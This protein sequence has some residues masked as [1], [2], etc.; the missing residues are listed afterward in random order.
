MSFYNVIGKVMVIVISIIVTLMFM[1][2]RM[3]KKDW[4]HGFCPK[5]NIRWRCFSFDSQGGRGY[6][7]PECNEHIWI[8][9]L[10]D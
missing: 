2:Y 4:N 8:S 6:K 3:D 10:V 9:Y 7:C 5:C 1:G